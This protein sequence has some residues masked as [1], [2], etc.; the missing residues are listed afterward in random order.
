MLHLWVLH[1]TGTERPKSTHHASKVLAS[2]CYGDP[3]WC[4]Q[5]SL[6]SICYLTASTHYSS[7]ALI[8]ECNDLSQIKE[9]TVPVSEINLIAYLTL[10]QPNENHPD[11]DLNPGR[12]SHQP[13]RPSWY[14]GSE[15]TLAHWATETSQPWYSY[16][17]K[18]Q[19]TFIEFTSSASPVWAP[20]L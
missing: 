6:A 7:G 19:K 9:D 5:W 13:V 14:C 12:C 1:P 4:T 20:G 2:W 16:Q 15:N 3:T 10:V 8:P 11:L 18:Q 17:R